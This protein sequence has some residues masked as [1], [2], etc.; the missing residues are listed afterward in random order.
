MPISLP[1]RTRR[2]S[3]QEFGSVAYDVMQHVFAIHN[4][5]GRFFDEV[6]Y[7]RELAARVGGVALEVPVTATHGSFSTVYF[8]DVLVHESD[9][10]EFKS[11]EAIHPR[12]RAQTINYLL[13][14]D[15]GHAK[16][17]NVR[18][19]KVE[20]EF[21][22][23]SLRLDELRTPLIQE[24]G[25]D[26]AVPGATVFRDTL[27]ALVADWGAGLE[28]SLYDG[29]LSHFLFGESDVPVHNMAGRLGVQR[30]RL[31]TPEVAFKLT[32]LTERQEMFAIHAHRLLEHTSL[33]AILWANVTHREVR[34]TTIQ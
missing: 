30:M 24:D 14:A 32:A 31:A 25:W 1:I 4:E 27:S 13:L 9:L 28:L 20:H 7:K 34:F 33:K 18:P 23:C 15:L 17:V 10:F 29:A 26:R 6:I 22:N 16:I 8:L 19:E 21:V 5:F 11:V 2:I 12:H 3:Q